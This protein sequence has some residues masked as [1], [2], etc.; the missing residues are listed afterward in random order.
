MPK[1]YYR[2]MRYTARTGR[3]FSWIFAETAEMIDII[4]ILHANLTFRVL[5]LEI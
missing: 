1:L 4:K 5:P 2:R 3:Y